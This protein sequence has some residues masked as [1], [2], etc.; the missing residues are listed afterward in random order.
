M[1]GKNDLEA[2]DDFFNQVMNMNATIGLVA[3]SLGYTMTSQDEENKWFV[4][5]ANY[6]FTKVVVWASDQ[7]YVDK[8]RLYFDDNI[9][10]QDIEFYLKR[11]YMPTSS[12]YLYFNSLYTYF[13]GYIEGPPRGLLYS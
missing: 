6:P 3:Y 8:V 9:T 7:G 13:L 4:T 11:F 1:D 12:P 10:F 2:Y 5:D